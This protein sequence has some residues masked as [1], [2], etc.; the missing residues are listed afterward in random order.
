MF[1]YTGPLACL[2]LTT[3]LAS[4]DCVG[5]TPEQTQAWEAQRVQAQAEE[6]LKAEQLAR[7]RAARRNDPMAWVRTLNPLSSGG[8][9]FR[10]VADDG[11]WAA[12]STN[13]Q[14]K[15]SGKSITVWLRQEYAEAQVGSDGRY[16]S[17]VRKVEYDCAKQRSRTL[18]VKYYGDNNIEGGEE[19]EES[20]AKTAPWDAIVPGTREEFNFSWAC[21]QK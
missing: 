7:E 16:R 17:L 21:G 3:L 2:A 6:K 20:D 18:L 9:E 8:W 4:V 19:T 1:K 5:Q 13:H 15:R 11:S 10:A 14:M 12:Y